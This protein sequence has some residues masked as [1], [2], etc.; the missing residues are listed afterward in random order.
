MLFTDIVSLQF[1]EAWSVAA[2]HVDNPGE[3]VKFR[4]NDGAAAN[5]S[6]SKNRRETGDSTM[7][8][9]GAQTVSPSSQGTG[10]QEVVLQTLKRND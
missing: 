7:A 8:A 9:A 10:W 1:R 2:A 5:M 3:C 4:R 6:R